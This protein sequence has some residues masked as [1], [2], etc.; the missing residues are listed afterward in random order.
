M[1]VSRSLNEVEPG[2]PAAWTAIETNAVGSA[3]LTEE[4]EV[5]EA[6]VSAEAAPASPACRR[7]EVLRMTDETLDE[8]SATFC[9][10]GAGVWRPATPLTQTDSQPI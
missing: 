7:A 10:D 1:A 9:A 3:R 2:Q 4:A 6:N 5:A 8:L